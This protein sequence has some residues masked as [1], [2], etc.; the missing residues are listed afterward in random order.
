MQTTKE[1]FKKENQ[2]KQRRKRKTKE[3]MER[4]KN[5]E[6]INEKEGER[7]KASHSKSSCDIPPKFSSLFS[8]AYHFTR[9]LPPSLP[10]SLSLSLSLYTHQFSLFRT[11]TLL[12]LRLLRRN[13]WQVRDYK[14]E[15]NTARGQK[16]FET[17]CCS[18]QKLFLRQKISN[19]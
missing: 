19:F 13:K 8:L 18:A 7:R 9:S 10:P 15:I 14:W 2:A 1:M 17:F 12:I 11:Y 5:K 6:R 16:G 3:E 4:N